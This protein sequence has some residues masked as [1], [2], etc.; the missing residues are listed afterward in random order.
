VRF[1]S[2][3]IRDYSVCLGY[4]HW[5]EYFPISLDWPHTQEREVDLTEYEASR[6]RRHTEELPMDPY[7]RWLRI[8]LVSGIQP[9]ELALQENE[10][11]DEFLE[12]QEQ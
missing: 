2:V 5:A 11:R 4:H 3:R 9:D 1:S 8:C 10:R 6:V 7:D 12:K